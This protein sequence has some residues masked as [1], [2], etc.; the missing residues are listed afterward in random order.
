M[1]S[2]VL[3][4]HHVQWSPLRSQCTVE[5]SQVTMYSG[6]LSGHNVQWSP[7]RSPCTVESSP[8]TMYIG[9]LSGHHVHTCLVQPYEYFNGVLNP[10]IT[11]EAGLSVMELVTN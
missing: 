11:R 7:L 3:S 2:G 5:S 10:V 8:V 4:G 6:V 9:V 1:Y